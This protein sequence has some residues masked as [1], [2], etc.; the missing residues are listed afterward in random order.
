MYWLIITIY[1]VVYDHDTLLMAFQFGTLACVQLD[2]FPSLN[3]VHYICSPFSG[4]LGTTWS[5][6][7]S[8]EAFP[9]FQVVSHP[10]TGRARPVPQEQQDFKKV[11][12]HKQGLLRS[13]PGT[14]TA[15]LLP[16]ST[17]SPESKGRKKI[18][19]LNGRCCKEL[20]PFLQYTTK[21]LRRI[22]FRKTY[23]F[24]TGPEYP[25][26]LDQVPALENRINIALNPFQSD[27]HIRYLL[28]QVLEM[29]T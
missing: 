14:H 7:A 1:S 17:G 19:F 29:I 27:W 26:M 11:V 25:V 4:H 6:G 10:P 22:L 3:W 18:P 21:S 16:Q 24:F 8:A 5:R 28:K 13:K 12:R 2:G 9:L 23:P 15:S 20:W